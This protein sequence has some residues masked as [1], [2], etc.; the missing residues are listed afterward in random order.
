MVKGKWGEGNG[1]SSSTPDDLKENLQRVLINK[2]VMK[3]N[4]CKFGIHDPTLKSD[5]PFRFRRG[6]LLGVSFFSFEGDHS[7][8]DPIPE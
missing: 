6:N 1:L 2:Y 4:I 8:I 3:I 7:H 5:L